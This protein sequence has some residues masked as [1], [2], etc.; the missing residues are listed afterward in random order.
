MHGIPLEQLV[1]GQVTLLP[2]GIAGGTDKMAVAFAQ[3]VNG[4]PVEQGRVNLLLSRRGALLSLQSTGLPNLERLSTAPQVSKRAALERALEAF[5]KDHGAPTR[6]GDTTLVIAKTRV[7]DFD[8]GRLAW[9]SDVA[10]REP[11]SPIAGEVLRVD[12]QSGE[13]LSRSSTVHNFDVGGQVVS[14]ATPGLLPNGAA[15]PPVAT[16]MPFIRVSSSAGTVY[17]DAAGNFDFPAATGPL[18]ITVEFTGTYNDVQ[19]QAGA[20]YVLTQ[21]LQPGQGNAVLMNASPTGQVTAQANA[22]LHTHT[23]RDYIRSTLP[24]DTTADFLAVSRP[25]TTG[26]C[27][28]FYDGFS[29]NYFRAGGGCVN[30]AYSTI[31][32]HEYGHWLNDAYG[33]GNGFDGMGEGNADVWSMYTF[34][35]PTIGLG[36]CTFGCSPRTGNNTRQ[37]CGDGN[38][39]CY[40]DVHDDGEVWMGAAWKVRRNLKATLGD[41]A[42]SLVADSLFLAWM[43]GFD[44]QS[45]DS[46]IELQWLT[47]DDDDGNLDNGTPNWLDIDAAFLEQ[48]FPGFSPAPVFFSNVTELANSTSPGPFT[49][50]ATVLPN[51][52]ASVSQVELYWRTYGGTYS[53]VPMSTSGNDVY[54]TQIPAQTIPAQVEYYL[55]ATNSNSETGFYPEAAPGDPLRF[56]LGNESFLLAFDFE[57]ASD[58]GW[59]SGAPGDDAVGGWW[60]RGDPIGS[61]YQT[62]DDVTVAGTDC[63][64]TGQAGDVNYGTT[65]LLS[66]VFDA[67]ALTSVRVRYWLWFYN[68]GWFFPSSD[69]LRIDLSNDGGSTWTNVETIGPFGAGT[70]GG[71]FLHES[72]LADYLPLTSAMR[73]RFVATDLGEPSF[74]EV[75]VDEFYVNGFT[76]CT[77]VSNTCASTVNSTGQASLIA[78]LGSTSVAANDLQLQANGL[79]PNQLGLFYY[80]DAQTQVPFGHGYRCAGGSLARLPVHGADSGGVATFSLD[81]N[82]LPVGGELVAG[83]TAYFQYWY[84]DPAS[85]APGFNL[86]DGLEAVFCP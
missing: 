42:G 66:P 21:T 37:Y 24:G 33:T 26:N 54:T 86:S 9:Q 35:V 70:T 81:L 73:M 15:N 58:Q 62:E 45:I 5:R 52:A 22:Y 8:Q 16:P 40:G 78:G 17:T 10:R 69:V 74:V 30:Y 12:A 4:V 36:A 71:W 79:P 18:Q 44:Q 11:G 63:W 61:A 39:A 43:N 38:L 19:N 32:A 20:D 27:N 82:A 51:F 48:G 85:G 13:L 68:K 55:Q 28:A 80:G 23:V 1:D 34:D 46:A 3:V 31:I 49:V 50:Q 60:E 77:G 75:A 6:V 65:T 59:V 14:M 83:D 53:A 41:S 25:N 7:G 84:R 2:L 47:L 64:F 56:N 57:G 72:L 29:L 67:S 76:G